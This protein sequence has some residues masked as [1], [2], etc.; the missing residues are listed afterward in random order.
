MISYILTLVLFTVLAIGAGVIHHKDR[1]IHHTTDSV[2]ALQ[3]EINKYLKG[4]KNV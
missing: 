4:G 1:K 3:K 2:A